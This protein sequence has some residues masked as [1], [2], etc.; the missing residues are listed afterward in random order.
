M[1]EHALKY[2]EAGFSVIPIKPDFDPVEQKFSKKPYTN[3]KA[4][5]RTLPTE[6]E[7]RSW[8]AKWPNAMIG[9]VTGEI[10]NIYAID[11]DTEDAYQKIQEFAPDSFL[12]PTVTTPRGGK[13]LW[14]KCSNGKCITTASGVMPSVDT[15]G[16]GGYII[17]PPSK[18]EHGQVY[19]WLDGLSLNDLEPADIPVSI[20]NNINISLYRD[21][22][23]SGE[24]SVTGVTKRYI[25]DAGTRDDNLYYVAQCLKD[26]GAEYDY[27]SQV[28]RAVIL[29]WGEVNEK[30]VAEKI[31]SA[32]NHLARKERNWQEDVD[33]YI[34][35][36]D[37][38]FSVT[39]CYHTLQAVTKLDKGAVRIALNRRKDKTIQKVGTK[40]GVYTKIAQDIDF[41][42]FDDRE[43]EPYLVKLPMRLGDLVNI[44][45][46]NIILVAGEYNAGK[47]TFLM[48]VLQANRNIFPIRYL[49]SEMDSGEFKSRFKG[50]GLPMS[51]WQP[52]EML[53]Y[54]RLK[55]TND[56]HH[57]LR[58]NAL[59]VIDYLEFKES[60]YYLGATIM[61]QIH[62]VLGKGI[63]II[64]IQKKGG[65]RLPRSG[66]MVLEKPRL[67]LTLSKYGGERDII[68]AEILKAKDVR[69]GKCDG[70][71]AKY[72]ILDKGATFKE[73][74]SWCWG[75]IE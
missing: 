44:H 3:W 70:K 48:N 34:L 53:E 67:A 41:I 72:E 46:G 29:S 62:D 7:I 1:L 13:H 15:R 30:W 61:Q 63:C 59:N 64:G 19:Q 37:G 21:V 75:K 11:C 6:D 38:T 4:Y 10:T 28:L 57:C 43:E 24:H 20:L 35:V 16:E 51:F 74:N 14:V 39:D 18:N 49:S 8:W 27:I 31:Q 56:Y 5:Q 2:R 22:T 66:D 42:T 33:R 47:T 36:T 71:K 17:A 12:T 40:D 23:K 25:W 69:M 65:V 9:I 50:F 58:A 26:C 60:D 45:T 73:L 32:V 52:D 55:S 54:V 68:I